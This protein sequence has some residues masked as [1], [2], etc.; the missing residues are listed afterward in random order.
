MAKLVWD[1]VGQKTYE[2]GV[3]QAALFVMEGSEYGKGVAWNGLQKVT[4][5]PSGA[6]PTALY[7]NNKKYLNLISN[8]D[9]ACTIEAYTYP[10]EFE[11]CDG[12]ATI[13]KGVTIGQQARKTFGLAYKTLIGNDTEGTT[14]GYKLHLVY[15]CVAKPSSKDHNTV[16][17]SPEAATMSWEIA[18]T[19]VD[20][21]GFRPSATITIDSTKTDTDKLKALED[22]I[23][24]TVEKEAA[25]PLPEKVIEIVGDIAG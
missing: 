14:Y 10:D 21:P 6:E 2:T 13:A 3:E 9:F 19:P 4:E 20:I 23:Y 8:E 15:G 17:E 5:S 18:T 25:L 11:A 12:S 22:Y 1:Q 24:G 7:A 16:N